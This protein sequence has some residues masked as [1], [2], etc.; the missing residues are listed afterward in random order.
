MLNSLAVFSKT[1]SF[2]Y[3]VFDIGA[4]VYYVTVILLFGFL[5]VQSV[6]KKRWN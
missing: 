5:T 3:G 2:M 4:V 6:D 1:Y